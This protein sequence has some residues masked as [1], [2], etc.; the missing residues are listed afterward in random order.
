MK[1]MVDVSDV[2]FTV[3]RPF[4]PKTD[5]EPGPLRWA[6]VEVGKWGLRSS[7]TPIVL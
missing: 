6:T 7:G 1:L 2:Q 4:A 5:Q 3:G